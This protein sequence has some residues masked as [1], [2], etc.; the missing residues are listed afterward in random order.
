MYIVR[1]THLYIW[2][3]RLISNTSCCMDDYGPWYSQP[4]ICPESTNF[5]TNAGLRLLCTTE[6]TKD[7]FWGLFTAAHFCKS[8]RSRPRSVA[9][10]WQRSFHFSQY[11]HIWRSLTQLALFRFCAVSCDSLPL[12][13]HDKCKISVSTTHTESAVVSSMIV[14]PQYLQHKAIESDFTA[15]SMK[16]PGTSFLSLC[17]QGTTFCSLSCTT[18]RTIASVSTCPY[19]RKAARSMWKSRRVEFKWHQNFWELAQMNFFPCTGEKHNS[20]DPAGH[21]FN[22]K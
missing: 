4:A 1:M 16:I 9:K 8:K 3:A 18:I 21:I 10:I 14:Q 6:A 19:R 17:G 2:K 20:W 11:L 22:F 13:R 7:T 5:C 15:N 12:V